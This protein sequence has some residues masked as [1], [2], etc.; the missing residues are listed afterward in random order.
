MQPGFSPYAPPAFE[1]A[2]PPELTRPGVI[3]WARIYAMGLALL[4]LAATVFGAFLMVTAGDLHGR[5]ADD[6]TMEGI[7]LAVLGPV[8]LG[9][10]VVVAAAPRKKWGWIVNVVLMGLSGTSC[11]CMPMV[12]P[13]LVFWLK[14]ETKRWYGMEE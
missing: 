9:F 14:P 12:I 6:L 5:E 13:L 4:Y 1:A 10:C 3:V 8:F 2:P 11:L 7:I